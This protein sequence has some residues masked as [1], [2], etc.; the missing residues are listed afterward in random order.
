MVFARKTH[1]VI[2]DRLMEEAHVANATPAEI[3]HY[4]S[5]LESV[6]LMGENFGVAFVTKAIAE[7]F[8]GQDIAVR[9]LLHP[10]LQVSSYLVLR[11]DQ[12]SRRDPH[13]EGKASSFF[14]R[15]YFSRHKSSQN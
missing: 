2:Y 11:A 5:P 4:V 7:Q 1:P 15:L 6:R 8:R 12:S 10:S 3:H 9:P 14:K 13:P